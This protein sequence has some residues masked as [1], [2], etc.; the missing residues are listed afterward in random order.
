MSPD[1]YTGLADAGGIVNQFII[2]NSWTEYTLAIGILVIIMV[3]LFSLL[4]ATGNPVRSVLPVVLFVGTLVCALGTQLQYNG[5]AL[6][7]LAHVAIL[8]FL[9]VLSIFVLAMK[10]EVNTG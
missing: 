10:S 4:K 3:I 2:V 6:F 7:T 1:E 5:L 8:G 9:L